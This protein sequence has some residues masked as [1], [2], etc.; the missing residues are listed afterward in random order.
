MRLGSLLILTF[1]CGVSAASDPFPARTP[2]DLIPREHT[3]ERAGTVGTVKYSQPGIGRF[4][5]FGYVNGA[6]FG[7]D[8][9]GFG[10]RPGRLF[11][12]LWP[13]GRTTKSFAKNYATDGPIH[14]PDP[15]GTKPVRKA[16]IE[17]KEKESK[18]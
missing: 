17:A 14:V 1:A 3:H 18:E 8:F 16:V 2:P 6:T 13:D 5:G 7:S 4:D 11:P 10:R 9:M 12:G 15:I